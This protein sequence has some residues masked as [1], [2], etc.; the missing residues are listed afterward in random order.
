MAAFT[1]E[2]DI[3]NRA[4]QHIRSPRIASFIDLSLEAREAAFAYPRIRDAELHA[5]LWRFATR[6]TVLYPIGPETYQWLP[7]DWIDAT[8]YSLGQV[9]V[10]AGGNLWQ[11][12]DNN[13]T[14]ATP[15]ST[16]GVDTG[17][18]WGAYFGPDTLTPF[19]STTLAAPAAPTLT[20]TA[21][22]SLGART[23]YATITYVG[24]SGEGVASSE[25][26]GAV[27]A[28]FRGKIT[29]PAASTG[30]THYNVYVSNSTGNGV[31]QN[32]SA[33][34]I[35]TD[36]TEALTGI[37]PGA[38]PP[39]AN[40]TSF[41]AGDLTFLPSTGVVYLSLVNGNTDTPPSTRWVEVDG[42]A[43]PLQILYPIGAGPPSDTT[44]SNVYRLPHGFLRQAPSDPKGAANPFLGALGGNARE[45]WV[46]EGNY[47]V[48]GCTGPLLLRYV[49]DFVDVIAMAPTFCEMV[50]AKM[51][52]ELAPRLAPPELL[53]ALAQGCRAAYRAARQTAVG[54]NAIETGPIDLDL[55]DYLA[56]RV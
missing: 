49:A 23:N 55:S 12:L 9:V 29:S 45:D 20:S 46:F 1:T 43:D 28:S 51:A 38:T 17:Q 54:L 31:R 22:G 48:S 41:F 44:T 11:S 25:S 33:I 19:Y 52:Q 16:T 10:D 18:S 14:V 35:G 2:V 8:T 37:G 36:W 30:A 53:G 27:A 40:P 34:A 21:G 4:L 15:N 7:P 50:A 24:P 3:A 56:C 42:T 6:R 39:T 26:S 32:A 47:I 5:H 13:N